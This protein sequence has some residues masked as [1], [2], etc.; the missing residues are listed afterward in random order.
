MD[1]ETIKKEFVQGM[2]RDLYNMFFDNYNEFQIKIDKK[3]KKIEDE[4]DIKFIK[5]NGYRTLILDN[6]MN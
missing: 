4:H 6:N 3:I 5:I 2:T 1:K